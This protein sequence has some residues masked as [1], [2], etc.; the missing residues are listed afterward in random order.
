[1]QVKVGSW[2]L[3]GLTFSNAKEYRMALSLAKGH[4]T[5]SLFGDAELFDLFCESAEVRA[6]L[7]VEGSLA[8]AQ[9]E[10][11]GIPKESA[12]VINSMARDVLIDPGILADG[13]AK[14][15]IVVPSLVAGF[16][17]TMEASAEDQGH[18]GFVQKGA[19]SQDIQDTGLVLWLRRVFDL[20]DQ[21]MVGLLDTFRDQALAYRSMPMAARTRHQL[22]KPTALGARIAAWGIPFVRHRKRLEQMRERVLVLSLGGASIC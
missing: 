18:A 12:L 2:G 20:F 14:D 5:R 22:A 10:I 11:G 4:I 17:A 21:R 3:L 16:V 1:V 8:T 19:T 9:G 15:G 7:M 6:I 13:M